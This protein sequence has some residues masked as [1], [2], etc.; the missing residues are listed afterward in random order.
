M[1]NLIL[2][3]TDHTGLRL[4]LYYQSTNAV[5]RTILFIIF[6]ESLWNYTLEIL[7]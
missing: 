7:I 6:H 2:T 3:D 5:L 1:P 4:L